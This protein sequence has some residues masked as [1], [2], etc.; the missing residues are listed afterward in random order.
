MEE[1]K[2]TYMVL[3]G[4]KACEDLINRLTDQAVSTLRGEFEETDFLVHLAESLAKRKS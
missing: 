1:N 4:E 3:L 2:N